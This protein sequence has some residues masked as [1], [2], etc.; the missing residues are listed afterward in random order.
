MLRLTNI[1]QMKFHVHL[2]MLNYPTSSEA[3]NSKLGL[4]GIARVTIEDSKQQSSFDLRD[5]I[6]S[7]ALRVNGRYFSYD[8]S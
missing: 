7:L 4:I 5:A 2:K 1:V 8:G 6:S 3:T